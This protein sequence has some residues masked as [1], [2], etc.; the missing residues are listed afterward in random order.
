MIYD[1]LPSPRLV[2]ELQLHPGNRINKDIIY[3]LAQ[4]HCN[5]VY[6]DI[7]YVAK[8]VITECHNVQYEIM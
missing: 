8:Y 6:N 3:T 5:N 4:I 1:V 7:L 2:L